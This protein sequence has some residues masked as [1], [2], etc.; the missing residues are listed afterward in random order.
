[1]KKRICVALIVFLL[2]AALVLPPVAVDVHLFLSRLGGYGWRPAWAWQQLVQG[3]SPWKFYGFF[4]AGL[5]LALFWAVAS[6]PSVQYRSGMYHVAPGINIP[7]PAGQ[8]QYGT[9]WWATP[10]ELRRTYTAVRVRK[11][12]LKELLEAGNKDYQE[13]EHAD[14]KIE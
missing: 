7:R 14:I 8:G 5:I 12:A 4:I 9:A 6:S 2:G 13:V 1:M 11:Q 3:G 10:K